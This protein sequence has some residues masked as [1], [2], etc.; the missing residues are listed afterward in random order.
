MRATALSGGECLTRD[1]GFIAHMCAFVA[2]AASFLRASPTT[3]SVP[4]FTD[5]TRPPPE[6]RR[7]RNGTEVFVPP[8]ESIISTSPAFASCFCF[9]TARAQTSSVEFLSHLEVDAQ[10]SQTFDRARCSL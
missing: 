10:C 9:D 3:L 2:P 6:G 7:V 1:P 4:S 8:S 5:I